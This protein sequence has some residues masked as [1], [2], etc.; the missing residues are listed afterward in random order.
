MADEEKFRI[1][2]PEEEKE[3]KKGLFR[4]LPKTEQTFKSSG[5]KRPQP[6]VKLLGFSMYEKNRDLLLLILIPILSALINTSIYSFVVVSIFEN[7]AMF[8]FFMPAIAA[9]P[10][11]LVVSETGKALIGGFLSAFF[12]FVFFV[13]F[14]TSPA[15]MVPQLGLGNFLVSG[16]TLTV[17][18]FIFVTVASLLGAVIGTIVREFG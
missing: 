13:L 4:P 16:I 11:G 6:V 9:I 18:Y 5:G 15:L 14:L 3:E 2:E 10:I 12:F 8:L 17:G 7:D 1:E